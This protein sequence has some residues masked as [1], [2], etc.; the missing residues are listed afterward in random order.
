[1]C[2]VTLI[3]KRISTQMR[4]SMLILTFIVSFVGLFNYCSI[5]SSLESLF[6]CS[7]ACWIVWL[8]DGLMQQAIGPPRHSFRTV[9]TGLK[10]GM[11]A[12]RNLKWLVMQLAP[13]KS[14]NHLYQTCIPFLGVLLYWYGWWQ[15]SCTSWYGKYPIIYRVSYMSGDCLVFSSINSIVNL[16]L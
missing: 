8:I 15:K 4:R 2:F 12:K 11:A 7:F 14:V 1:M 3:K 10:Y 6:V 13:F 5:V 9:A 16:H